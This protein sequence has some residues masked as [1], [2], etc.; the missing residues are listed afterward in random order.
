[1]GSQ[2]S[3]RNCNI[4][5]QKSSTS[6]YN[7][8]LAKEGNFHSEEIEL[9]TLNLIFLDLSLRNFSPSFLEKSSFLSFIKVPVRFIQGILGERLFNM[10]DIDKDGCILFPEFL[11]LCKG[12]CSSDQNSFLTKFFKICDFSDDGVIDELELSAVVFFI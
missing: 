11:H 7:Q 5:V 3:K 9:E 10:T 12:I 2:S 1:M 8:K 6:E 4:C